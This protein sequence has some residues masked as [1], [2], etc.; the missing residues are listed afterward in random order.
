MIEWDVCRPPDADEEL[1]RWSL[2]EA[3]EL[4]ALRT[5]LRAAVMAGAGFGPD[6]EDLAERLVMVGTELAGNAL[7]HAGSPAL[8]VLQRSAG[9]LV[10]VISDSD[11][12]TGPAVD[13]KRPAGQGGLGLVLA[14]RLATSVGWH[15]TSGGKLVW[16]AFAPPP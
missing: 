10:I 1:A 4:S 2:H 15:P 11:A 8:V 16:A 7:R 6:P 13:R 5:G 12:A 9:T 14:Q 3:P